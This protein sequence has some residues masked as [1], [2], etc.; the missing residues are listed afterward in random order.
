MGYAY[1]EFKDASQVEFAVST[2]DDTILADRKI[3]VKRK[4]TNEAGKGR[5]RGG[6]GGRG[7]SFRGGR[8]GG[9]R[10]GRRGGGRRYKPY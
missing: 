9:F 1:M 3:N 2:M 7:R 8:R 4:R 10:G 5:G 6:G